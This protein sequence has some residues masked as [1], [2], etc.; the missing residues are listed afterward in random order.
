MQRLITYLGNRITGVLSGFD[1]LIF[2]GYIRA[3]SCIEL[4]EHFLSHVSV[5]RKDFGAFT[6]R[7]TQAISDRAKADAQRFGIPFE[8]LPSSAT[9]KEDKARAFLAQ[10]KIITG[11]ICVLST[12]E[13]CTTWEVHRVRER[14]CTELRRRIAKC[15]HLYSYFVH[16]RFGFMHVRL[17][18]WFPFQVQ[19]YV[20][21][22]EYLGRR[23]DQQR[24]VYRRADNCFPYIADLEHAQE[25]IDELL[26]MRWRNVLDGFASQVHPTLPAILQGYPTQYSW[27]VYQSEWATDFLFKKQ[28][29]LTAIYPHIVHVAMTHFSSDD[30]MRFLGKKIVHAFRGE[31]V[32]SFKRRLDGVR[33]KH[34]VGLNSLKAY[35]KPCNLRIEATINDASQFK[36][37]RPAQGEGPETKALRSLRKGIADLRP[38]AKISHTACKRYADAI[39]AGLDDTVPLQELLAAITRPATLDGQRVR[40]MHPLESK[41]L[42]LLKA[43]GRGEFALTGFRNRDIAAILFPTT[44]ASPVE[45]R[46]RSARVTRLLRLLRAHGLV[47]KRPHSHRYSLTDKGTTVVAASI[48]AA[49]ATIAALTRCA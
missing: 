32:T 31:V 30:V 42:A 29:A 19:V 41:D 48:A 22:R 44:D 39:A 18:T 20:N 8:Y 45:R 9:N 36:I 16:P 47:E 40:P 27:S 10:R 43:I 1:R 26:A 3:F 12:I 14:K 28:E 15:L 46:R 35:D 25:V 23:L 34:W 5:L 17:Q 4:F 7:T 6:Q 13:P 24:R 33:V 49:N 11:P 21:G 37:Y 2:R 38:R